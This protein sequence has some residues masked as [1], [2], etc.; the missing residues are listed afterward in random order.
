MIDFL[1]GIRQSDICTGDQGF[2]NEKLPEQQNERKNERLAE[3]KVDNFRA[4]E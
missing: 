3:K 1:M 2:C 4:D